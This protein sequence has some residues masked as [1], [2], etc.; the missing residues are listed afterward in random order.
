MDEAAFQPTPSDSAV[1]PK[2]ESTSDFFTGGI[3]AAG[4]RRASPACGPSAQSG[5]FL[6]CGRP[7]YT[8]VFL[9]LSR[10]PSRTAVGIIASST[11]S[12]RAA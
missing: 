2:R 7:G 9:L 12:M 10:V 3:A 1:A 6:C 8:K 5:E 11:A 4:I